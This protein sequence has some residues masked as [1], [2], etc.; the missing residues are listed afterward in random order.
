MHDLDADGTY[1]IMPVDVFFGARPFA[2]LPVHSTTT[3][4]N[5][6]LGVEYL[7]ECAYAPVLHS[8]DAI[9]QLL[10]AC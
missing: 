10:Q 6:R 9:S 4:L 5:V 8:T 3:P 7:S 2:L 1:I